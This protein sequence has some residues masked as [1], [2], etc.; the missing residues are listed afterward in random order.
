VAAIAMIGKRG[1][2]IVRRE[3]LGV[4]LMELL[5]VLVIIAILSAIAV[6][7]YRQYTL[8]AN[9]SEAKTTLLF[10]SSALE[11]CYTRFN[12]YVYTGN[13]AT[14][15]TVNFPQT[16]ENG[17][18][19]IS[20]APMAGEADM[21]STFVLTATPQGAQ[22]QDTGCATLTLDST[23]AKGSTGTKSANECWGK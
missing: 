9:R 3:Q 1:E 12:S 6:P 11:R 13:A 7:S 8:R 16:S 5:T 18:Y 22:T 14:G 15:C 20:A 4:T 10:L 19:T 2:R 23:N 17:L 21:T